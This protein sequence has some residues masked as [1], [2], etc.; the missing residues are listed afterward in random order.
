MARIS[1]V[2]D[3]VE[4]DEPTLVEGFPGVGLV[5]KIATDHLIEAHEMGHYA[6]VHCDG[7]PRVAVYRESSPALTTPV[8]LYADAEQD[9]IALRSDVPVHPNAATEFAECLDTWLGKTDVFPVFLSGLG[10]EKGDEPP[11]LYGVS[12]GDGGDSLSRADVADP[13]EPGLV[14]G[15]TG[16]MLAASLERDRDAV[17]LVVES[18]PQVPDPEASRRLISDGIDPIAGIETPTDGLVD[19]AT[20]IRNAKQAFAERMQEAS[21]ESSQAEPLKMYQ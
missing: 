4:L 6:N 9:L 12:T 19:Q 8:R 10:R 13:P 18:D 3:G 7:L 21:E 16:A 15:P 5:G 11:A 20:E 2:D 1:I 17:G 14:S